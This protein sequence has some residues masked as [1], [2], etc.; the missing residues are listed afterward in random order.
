MSAADGLPG[1]LPAG[2]VVLWQGRPRAAAIARRALHERWALGYFL[3]VCLYTLGMGLAEGRS[4]KAVA[5]SLAILGLGA[6]AIL[7]LARGF[8]YLIERTTR[9]TITNRRVV[10]RIGVALPLTLN[11]PF[12][13][14]AAA[15]VRVDPDGTGDIPLTLG[16]NGRISYLHLWP[17]ARPWRIRRPEPMLRGIPEAGEV[18]A[19]LARAIGERDASPA[20]ARQPATLPTPAR[21]AIAA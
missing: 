12:A 21:P 5:T 17:H 7:V 15:G 11:V 20:G 18:A 13:I 1:P 10:M 6:L 9:Y 14:I 2:E 4:A 3:A 19:L 16:G 8:A